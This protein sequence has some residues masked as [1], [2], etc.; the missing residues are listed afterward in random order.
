MYDQFAREHALYR[1]T[2]R[3][4]VEL[5]D[6]DDAGM[7]VDLACGTGVTTEAILTRLGPTAKVIALDGSD[8]M[9]S[10]A[11]SRV[12]DP[13]VT[14]VCAPAV[15]LPEFAKDANAIVCNSAIWQLDMVPTLA[16][17]AQTLQLGGRLVCNI[18]RQFLVLPLTDSELRPE[19]PTLFHLIQAVA[20][21]EHDYVP[22]H[23]ASR[24]GPSLTPD[25]VEDM[26][27]QAGLVPAEPVIF[28]YE[29]SPAAQLAWLKVPV[30][31]QNVLPGLPYETQV[32]V[33][34]RAYARLDKSSGPPNTWMAF[35]GTKPEK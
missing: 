33:L 13:R 29:N 21:L 19:K 11:K 12:T 8:A 17:A 7:V 20:V 2:S 5:A 25:R 16:A 10:V 27:R 15:E 35:V 24:R 23:P 22:A 34:D 26:F 32:A 6:I 14:W 9:L 28:S 3:D 4:L 1:E 30:F 31:T 18:G